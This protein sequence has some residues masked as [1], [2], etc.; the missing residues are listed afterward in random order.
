MGYGEPVHTR[1]ILSIGEVAERSGIS[2]ATVRFYEERGLVGSVRTSGNQRRFERHTLRRIAVVRAGQRFGLS[3]ADIGEA[4]GVL[5]DD[6]PPSKRDWTRLSTHWR[7]LLTARIEAMTRVRDEL[8]SCIGCGC[9]SL[10]SC[11]VYNPRDTLAGEGPGP[12]RWPRA[13]RE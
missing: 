11:P 9:L 7:A 6:R 8:S 13:A 3:L 5:P 2:V 4:L 10:R 1:D 12:R